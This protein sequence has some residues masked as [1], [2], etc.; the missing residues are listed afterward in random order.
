MKKYKLTDQNMCTYNNTQWKIGEE[1]T[2]SGIGELCSDGWLHYYHHPLLAILLN[3]THANIKNPRLFE[4][5]ALGKHK[6]NKKLKGGC[7][8]MTIVKE[9]KLPKITLNQKI[10]FEILCSL[11][12]YKKP[13]F[14]SWATNWLNNIDRTEESAIRIILAI[15]SAATTAAHT[16]YVSNASAAATAAAYAV[17]VSNAA[18]AYAT[19]A[20]Y[21]DLNLIKIAKKAMK[22]N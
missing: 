20:T 11:E 3:L 12:V 17:Y 19:Y 9:I 1:K 16:V 5:K 13:F 21:A 10:A 22:Y 8:K 4:V 2:S 18:A 15:A 6:N 7:T 14:V